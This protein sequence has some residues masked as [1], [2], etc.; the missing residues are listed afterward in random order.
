MYV[1]V[2]SSNNSIGSSTLVN[3]SYKSYDMQ[4]CACIVLYMQ[5]TLLMVLKM[6]DVSGLWAH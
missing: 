4:L 3:Y 5:F 1:H 6:H 2:F